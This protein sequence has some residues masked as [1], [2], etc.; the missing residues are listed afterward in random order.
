MNRD[1]CYRIPLENRKTRAKLIPMGFYVLLIPLLAFTSNVLGKNLDWQ[2]ALVLVQQNNTELAAAK[3]SYQAVQ[4]LEAVARSGF[5]PELSATVSSTQ[6]YSEQTSTQTQRSES[7]A[8]TLS[9]NLFAG[10]SDL[11]KYRQ[12]QQNT[13]IAR[14]QYQQAK[15]KVSSDF[16]NAYAGLIYAQDYVILTQKILARRAEN[17]S[18]VQLRFNSGRENK[19]SLLLSDAYHQQ[20]VYDSVQATLQLDVAQSALAQVLGLAVTEDRISVTKDIPMSALPNLMDLDFKKT[21]VMT[22]DYQKAVAQSDSAQFAY[23]Q[24]KSHY[25]PSLN[26]VGSV[27]RID[28]EFPPQNDR[29][30]IGLNL[31][32]PLYSGGSGSANQQSAKYQRLSAE[33]NQ[34]TVAYQMHVKLK[35]A[36][37][38]YKLAIE[39]VKVDEK[40]KLAAQMRSEIAKKKYN[41]GL[42]TFENWDIVENDL[43]QREKSNLTSFRDRVSGQ[44]NWEQIQGLGL[45]NEK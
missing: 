42:M 34:S 2:S 24:S 28:T 35:Q 30:S 39:K 3:E 15:A 4:S 37:S 40:F 41:N 22:L 1:I 31:T 12:A 14:L 29:W 36:Y 25:F 6:S 9:Q 10:F 11:N 33:I 17:L 26:L 7:A 5:L 38:Q 27:G 19:G 45:F 44:S 18:I 13:L 8:L 20:A 23:E 16:K 32:L 21:A 43:I